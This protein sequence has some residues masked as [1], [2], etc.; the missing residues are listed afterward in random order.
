LKF[1]RPQRFAGGEPGPDPAGASLAAAICQASVEVVS[2]TGRILPITRDY[3]NMAVIFPQF[4]A[5]DAKIMIEKEMLAEEEFLRREFQKFG[6]GPTIQ[7]VAME[8]TDE[9][10]QRA[11]DLAADADLTVL[12]CYD[13]HLFPSNKKLLDV[14]QETAGK[15][16]VDLLRDP[17]DA[18]Y[19]KEG[20]AC[21]SDFGWR[22]CQVRAAVERICLTTRTR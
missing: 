6:L 19:I 4:S 1:Q 11:A 15:L 8:P 9:E 17:Y 5:L 21:L 10:V 16:V 3:P 12:F 18:A 2:D 7:L 20:V 22:A 13:A 14:L